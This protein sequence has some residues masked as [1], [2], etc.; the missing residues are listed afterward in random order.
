M[1]SELWFGDQASFNHL[2]RLEDKFFGVSN[3]IE[4]EDD[5]DSIGDTVLKRYGN[6]GVISVRGSLTGNFQW[7]H[8]KF[9]VTSYE[10][11]NDALLICLRD[12]GITQI[13]LDI[14]SGGGQVR[15]LSTVSDRIKQV[16]AVKPVFA[17][18]DSSAFS[19]AY[20]IACSARK[21]TASQMAEVGS[22][23]TLMVIPVFKKSYE[24][25]GVDI[26]VFRSGKFK[27]IGNGYEELSDEDKNYLQEGLDKANQFFLNHVSSRRN[28]MVSEKDMWAE[29]K[30][31][32]AEE[33]KSVG[34]IDAVTTLDAYIKPGDIAMQTD[35]EILAAQVAAGASV[36]DLVGEEQAK[37]VMEPTELSAAK[38][39]GRLEV[40][41]ELAQA[42]LEQVK[43][44]LEAAETLKL[45]AQD[46]VS[47]LQTALGLPKEQKATSL[48]IVAQYND[49]QAQM[50]AKFARGQ[51][52]KTPVVEQ[53]V[54]HPGRSF[55]NH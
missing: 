15:L 45:L 5:E 39:I 49:L 37:V 28:L 50:A 24:E 2:S 23:G 9:G 44:Q 13:V 1:R 33:A 6:T 34:L 42:E 41:L 36:E 27:A 19:A 30:T 43:Q 16:N 25:N 20:W 31:F 46:A 8:D 52:T 54:A 29:G 14:S 21:V 55:R 22:I 47:K 26:Y 51:Q 4:F 32:Y 38:E 11:I 18:T 7:W 48:E 10:A 12:S 35:A 40:K 53:N 3:E 17:H